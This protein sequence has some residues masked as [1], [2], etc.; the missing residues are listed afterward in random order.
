M[1]RTYSTAFSLLLLFS[2]AS[3]LFAPQAARA[4]VLYALS[5]SQLLLTLDS[6]SQEVTSATPLTGLGGA[7]LVGIDFRPSTGELYGMSSNAQFWKINTASGAS[8]AVGSPLP[9]IDL[10]KSFD[11]DPV[12]DQIRLESTVRRNTR[13]NP[14]TGTVISSDALLAY[15]GGDPNAGSLPQVVAMAYT[16][17]FPGAGSTTLFNLEALKDVLTM[18]TPEN[19]GVLNTVGALGIPLGTLLSV[20]GMDISGTTGI[21]YVVGS[22]NLG[23]G[24]TA[25]TLYTVDLAT[26]QLA[27]AGPITN[28]PM[29]SPLTFG[30]DGGHGGGYPGGNHNPPTWDPPTWEPH[31]PGGYECPPM[32]TFQIVDVATVPIPEPS[33]FV[34]AAICGGLGLAGAVRK[35]RARRRK[36]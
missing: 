2:L 25:N 28:G 18:Q 7:S 12:S 11:F 33:T 23:N 8:S 30:D 27:V 17:S 19:A 20:N 36:V 16:N 29:A 22:A 35:H 3:G 21:G 14:N 32:D 13:V 4:E 31:P 24:M 34:L 10:V 9:I 26:G 1:F 6:E 5:D 15:A